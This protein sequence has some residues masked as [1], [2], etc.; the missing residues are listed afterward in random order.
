[1]GEGFVVSE[2]LFLQSIVSASWLEVYF[3][4]FASSIRLSTIWTFVRDL[5]DSAAF[6]PDFQNLAFLA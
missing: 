5:S 1:L 4:V 3:A 6:G 2:E